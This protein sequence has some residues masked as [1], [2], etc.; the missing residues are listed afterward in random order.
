MPLR[1]ANNIKATI[2]YPTEGACNILLAINYK[3]ACVIRLS[4]VILNKRKCPDARAEGKGMGGGG[5]Q[6]SPASLTTL[7]QECGSLHSRAIEEVF[8]TVRKTIDD[9]YRTLYLSLYPVNSCFRCGIQRSKTCQSLPLLK[10]TLFERYNKIQLLQRLM[11]G[12]HVSF[13]RP[14][15]TFIIVATE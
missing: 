6:K 14:F 11:S 3:V 1:F 5:R 10:R 7:P 8:T 9:P 15:L 12:L 4:S 13:I 2:R